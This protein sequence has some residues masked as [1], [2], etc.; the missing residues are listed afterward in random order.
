MFYLIAVAGI[1][2][3]FEVDVDGVWVR[4]SV[5]GCVCCG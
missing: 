4:S 5:H 3:V 2:W 1:L